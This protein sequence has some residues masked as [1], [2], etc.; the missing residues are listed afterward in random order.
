MVEQGFI[1]EQQAQAAKNEPI[2]LAGKK[3]RVAQA[4]YFMDYVANQLV[5]RYGADKVYRGGL[6]VYTGLDI[7]MQQAAEAA[8]GKYQGAFVAIDT[9]TG[10]IRAMVGGR[11]YQESQLNRAVTFYR[12]PG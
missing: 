2:R 12:Q 9:K 11:N 5:E 4:S 6:R 1:T 8:L 10:F 7:D 3:P